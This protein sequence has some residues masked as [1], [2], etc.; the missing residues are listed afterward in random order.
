MITSNPLD[1]ARVGG[2]VGKPLHGI[3][4]RV[5]DDGGAAAGPG[6]IGGVQVRGPNIFAGY[7]QMPDKTRDEFTD[8][9]YLQDRRRRRVGGRR[10]GAGLPAARRSRQGP[11]HLRRAQRLPEGDRGAHRPDGRRASSRRSSAMP[12]P[13]FGEVVAAFVV[14]KPG[15]TLERRR[16][17]Q[18]TARPRSR[19]SR[20]RSASSSR[21]RC[22]ATRWARC[23]R[24]RCAKSWSPRGA[25]VSCCA[26]ASPPP[27]LRRG[28]GSRHCAS[29]RPCAP[30]ATAPCAT[31]PTCLPS[32]TRHASLGSA[33]RTACGPPSPLRPCHG[34][35]GAWAS[36][37]PA[38]RAFD[39]PIAIACLAERAPCLPSRT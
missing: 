35:R 29:P 15:C 39:K 24:P 22:R 18:A 11:H 33:S 10:T 32:S 12:D 4:V 36:F 5:V 19:A 14:R 25:S 17:H 21:T 34:C 37:T 26:C 38:R 28:C 3:D 13:D 20:C 2:T 8:D 30:G 9:G 27:S 23:R 31:P 16:H 6:V 7:W 1:G